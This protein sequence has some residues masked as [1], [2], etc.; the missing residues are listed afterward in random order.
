MLRVERRPFLA[1]QAVTF[2][3]DFTGPHILVVTR[4]LVPPLVTAFMA[5]GYGLTDGS[6]S[7]PQGRVPS[8]HGGNNNHTHNHRLTTTWIL[9]PRPKRCIVCPTLLLFNSD[10]DPGTDRINANISQ[11]LQRFENI[12][13]T[14]TVS[15]FFGMYSTEWHAHFSGRK[16]KPC[17][18]RN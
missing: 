8:S 4:P 17:R 7:P 14:A 13:A 3:L 18:D 16:H 6:I 1:S 11:L 10:P 9:S 12:M 2:S 5:P 15:S